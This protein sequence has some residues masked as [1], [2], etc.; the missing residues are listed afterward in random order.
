[1]ERQLEKRIQDIDP[2][3]FIGLYPRNTEALNLYGKF[4]ESKRIEILDEPKQGLDVVVICSDSEKIAY[5]KELGSFFGKGHTPEIVMAGV[6]HMYSN[7]TIV[8]EFLAQLSNKSEA[9]GYELAQT[10]L[11]ES[12]K[13][14]KNLDLKGCVV[15]LGTFK[16]GTITFL[17]K[18][19]EK[20]GIDRKLKFFGFDAW[21]GKRHRNDF[22]DLFEMQEWIGDDF[23][24]VRREV[25][26]EIDL[27]Q[28]E[29]SATFPEWVLSHNEPI[30]LAFIDTDNYSPT[31]TSLPLIWDRLVVGGSVVFDHYFTH[32]EF[33]N[34]IGEHIAVKDFFKERTDFFNL[35]GTGVFLKIRE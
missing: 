23:A 30:V 1:M 10:H 12:L 35:T 27:V 13:V 14:V 25:L 34:T 9:Q 28:G 16:G 20:F 7:K 22:L 24:E 26:A 4:K 18:L 17:Y 21:D 3:L 19:A 31:V 33:F 8:D 6:K 2:N 15:E 11:Y 32:E 29:I 5:L